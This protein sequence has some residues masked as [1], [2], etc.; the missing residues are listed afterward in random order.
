MTNS[1]ITPFRVDIPQADLD[2]LGDR[3]ERTRWPVQL[4]G[5]GWE[6]GAPVA[7]I[8]ALAEYWRAGFDWRAA[9]KQ[10]NEYPQFTTEIDGASIHFLHA[11]SPEETALPLILTHGWP[12]SFVEFLKVIGPLTDPWAHGGDPADAFHV[13]IPSI[14]GFG[15]STLPGP[16]WNSHR[17]AGAWA[18]LMRRLGYER[19]G[20]QGGDFGAIIS[21]DL[22]RAEPSRVVGVHVNAATVGFIPLGPIDD[23]DMAALSDLDRKRLGMIAH[24]RNE[25]FGYNI[26]QST[27]PATVAFGLTDSPAGQL[28]WIGEK[29]TAWSGDVTA[30][31]R[32]HLVTNISLYWLTASAGS[33]AS[34]YYEGAHGEWVMPTPSGVPTGVTVFGQDVAIRRFAERSN[35]ITSWHDVEAGGHFAAM[36]TPDLLVDDVRA[37]FRS[38]R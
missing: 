26:L 15:F 33:S 17:T 12:G 20:A 34:I 2:D 32:D 11:R 9:E 36:E 37:F 38:L 18:E 25:E 13:V 31:D 19:Y 4:P 24:F 29:F 5:T 7:H 35:T 1:E 3:L 23:A 16:G 21:P 28:A 6:R 27:R 22:G 14:P 10:I 30:I 8:Q